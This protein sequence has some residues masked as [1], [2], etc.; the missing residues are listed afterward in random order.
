[1]SQP[2]NIGITYDPGT[3]SVTKTYG[4]F[5][6]EADLV[7]YNEASA[8]LT[9]KDELKLYRT[10]AKRNGDFLGMAKSTA[11]FTQDY[12][13]VDA[14]GNDVSEKII[15]TISCSRYPTIPNAALLD[16]QTRVA[17]FITSAEGIL[18]FQKLEV[19]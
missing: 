15:F 5:K 3:G 14:A 8:T 17:E 9:A 16:M 1:M 11:K 7:T 10:E 4:R 19:Y 12:V 18:L 2:T 13:A 6:T